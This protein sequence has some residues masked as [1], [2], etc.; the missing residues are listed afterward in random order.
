MSVA[1]GSFAVKCT[2]RPR[3]ALGEV[4][5]RPARGPAAVLGNLNL[6]RGFS[7]AANVGECRCPPSPGRVVKRNRKKRAA[8]WHAVLERRTM[9]VQVPVPRPPGDAECE[10][11]PMSF[12]NPPPPPPSPFPPSP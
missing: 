3:R 1:G 6:K 5:R 4:P 2:G 12:D 9:V 8:H 11:S 10:G 7:A